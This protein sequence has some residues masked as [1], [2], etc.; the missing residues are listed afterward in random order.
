M[1]IISKKLF[2]QTLHTKI[3]PKNLHHKSNHSCVLYMEMHPGFLQY[4]VTDRIIPIQ[5]EDI[6]ALDNC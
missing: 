3:C 5:V 6:Q 1:A 2:G 4:Y